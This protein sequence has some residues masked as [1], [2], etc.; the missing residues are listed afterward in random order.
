MNGTAFDE[1]LKT[2]QPVPGF[3]C[4]SLPMNVCANIRGQRFW[5][6]LLK[7]PETLF[8]RQQSQP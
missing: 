3:V 1:S 8:F 2:F 4:H 6:F 7:T 5:H